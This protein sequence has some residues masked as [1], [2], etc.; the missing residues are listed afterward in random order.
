MKYGD[1]I[2]SL[3]GDQIKIARLISRLTP[4]PL[5]NLY[6]GIIITFVFP[7]ALG[8]VLTPFAN[9]IICLVFMVI[10]PV[11]PIVLEAKRGKVDLDISQQELRTPFFIW[12][13]FCYA[14]V[15]AIYWLLQCDVMRVLAAAYFTVTTG[16]MVANFATKVSVH[17]AG[18]SGPSTALIIIYGTPALIFV[19]LWIIVAWSRVKLKQHTFIQSFVGILIGVIITMLTYAALW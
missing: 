6:A 15:Y 18:V 8:P 13:L 4:A 10:A 9:I 12:A 3:E 17:A 7:V 14:A 19:I 1:E 5:I 2:I 11:A 16:V